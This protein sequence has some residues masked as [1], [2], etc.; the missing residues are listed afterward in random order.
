M[1]AATIAEAESPPQ[2]LP[3]DEIMW[4]LQLILLSHIPAAMPFHYDITSNQI[5]KE[6]FPTWKVASLLGTWT[7]IHSIIYLNLS[8]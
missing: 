5:S 1:W 7:L 8:I 3:V 4:P 2:L 6:I